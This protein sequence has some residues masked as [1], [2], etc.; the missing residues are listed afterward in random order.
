MKKNLI[1]HLPCK[2]PCWLKKTILIMKLTVF[3][4]ILS[5]MNVLAIESYPQSAVLS[6]NLKSVTIEQV[7]QKIEANSE[8][9]FLYNSRLVDVT[10]K[11]DANYKDRK[12]LDILEDLFA[13][14]NVDYT[15]KD[16]QII[17]SP[18]NLDNINASSN[19]SKLQDI[20]ISGT[21]V[22]ASGNP[23]PGVN[24]VEKGTLNG[25]VTD[26]DGKYTITVAS[27]NSVLIFSFIG[28]LTEEMEAG[29]ST[30]LNVT[31]IEDIMR[32]DEVVVVGYGTVKKSDITGALA[33]VTSEKIREMPVYNVNQAL[34]GRAAGVD[35]VNNSFTANS[36]PMIRIRG[37]R[38]IKADNNPM[39][40]VDG[41][42]VEA[43]ISEI[44]P[45]D[46]ESIEVLKD[47]SATA[48]YGSRAA[49]GVVL[50]TTKR[51][52]A[53]KTSVNYEGS[54]SF[55]NPLV[56][57]Y[58][59]N[60]GEW[61]ETAR[62][63]ARYNG[64]YTVPYA[65][66]NQDYNQVLR[67]LHY[68]CWESVKMGYEWNE[69]GTMKMRPTTDE[70]KDR[71]GVDQVP[72]YDPSKVR[73][74]DWESEALVKNAMS[75]N[76]QFSV[77]GGSEKIAAMLSVGYVNRN[78][79]EIGQHF[80]RISPRLNLDV[81]ASKWLKVGTGNAYSFS[82]NDPGH[83]MYGAV[84]SQLP[85][86][87][88]NDTLGEFLYLPTNDVMIKNPLRD[89]SLNT[90][91]ERVSRYM[92]SYYAEVSLFQGLKYRL[93]VGLDFRHW[94]NGYFE[95]TE[96]SARY[97]SVNRVRYRQG[98]DLNWTVENLL[99]YNKDIGIHSF[100]ATLLQSAGVRRWENTY[101]VG[102]NYPYTSMLWY[103]T[104]ATSDPGTLQHESD[105]ERRQIASYMG[106]VNYSLKDK[107]LLT[108]SLRYDG[109]SVFY[110]ENQWDYFPSFAL[111]WKAHEEAFLKNISAITQMKL[112]FGYGT[113]G[114]SATKPYETDG[115]LKESLYLFGEEPA[116]GFAPDRIATRNVGWEKTTSTN[117][118]LDFGL[119]RNRISGSIDI[120]NANT[121][122]LLL[123]K[124]IP[125]V[126]GYSI[127]RANVGKVRN[128]GIE[129]SVSSVNI[130][131][132]GGFKWETDFVF[133]SN[134]EEIVELDKDQDD[135]VNGWFRGYPVNSWFTYKYEGIWQISDSAL[136]KKYNRNSN[137]TFQ[138][139]NI[140]VAD[141]DGN[142][143]I[144][145]NDR[146]VVGHNA[147]KF[148]GGFT[149]RFSYKGFELSAFIY[150][151]VGQGI[152]SRDTHYSQLEGRYNYRFNYNYYSPTATEAENASA[153]HPV[154]S[155]SR[156]IYETAIWYKDASFA[157]IRH[158]TLAYNL[159]KSLIS[160]ANIESLSV[161]VMATNPF[162]FT[163][164][165]FLDPE[166]QG[167]FDNDLNR[168]ETLRTPAGISQKGWVFGVRIGL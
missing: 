13:G 135:I 12:I 35:I 168:F 139:G 117:L 61:I 28:Y 114:Q 70:E 76:H 54:L 9:F 51:G 156:D 152:Y 14:E 6:L 71:W 162:L 104:Q 85:I 43:G 4:C 48:I 137:L 102:E 166:A 124:A 160:R 109:S 38:S 110:V 92:G 36:A 10:R 99:F 60:G 58:L 31:L 63:A 129:L 80:E 106:R 59:P 128:R 125:S 81:E 161:Y 144:N 96:S 5:F 103:R 44:N 67:N 100:G 138:A 32:L 16:R 37:N 127:V 167:S 149:N 132:S 113:T 95:D 33:S 27:S 45:M 75:H 19:S 155:A 22:D 8:F 118:G 157:K 165:K 17:L 39:Y 53:G 46:V 148:T 21:I 20:I 23:L 18:Q 40:V 147:P 7:L 41:I 55:E 87:L 47:A 140:R 24:V 163:N 164:Y 159:P 107:Y 97:P 62:T 69:N 131:T 143:T 50:I 68:N 57:F 122:D 3:L 98:Q 64:R 153:D 136:M 126:T 72:I 52:K 158:I 89:E 90:T 112:R 134:K 150:F 93:N 119:L 49:N 26:L 91:E 83:G 142:D 66:Y 130:N 56:K 42:P 101:M 105:Y 1:I 77:L 121:N 151:R 94:R 74:Y 88:P 78:G 11:V 73:T 154:P 133:S 34:Q 79:L 116:K 84:T 82:L 15:V 123:D 2:I 146:V 29:S 65:D 145:A 115:T 120:Y 86:S 108:A 141:T 25:A 111:A 30:T